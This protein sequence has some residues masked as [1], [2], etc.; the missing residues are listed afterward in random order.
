[1]LHC[2]LLSIGLQPERR[3]GK[4][5]GGRDIHT[6]HSHFD[7]Y[8]SVCGNGLCSISHHSQ[9][10]E[11]KDAEFSGTHTGLDNKQVEKWDKLRATESIKQ[12]TVIYAQTD[13][14]MDEIGIDR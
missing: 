2:P 11:G 1:M 6:H 7:T 14:E 10:L 8:I 9:C 3:G 12:G 5:E 4:E 13:R